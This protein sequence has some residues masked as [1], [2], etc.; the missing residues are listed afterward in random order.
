MKKHVFAICAYKE[1]PYLE[2]CI[3]SLRA[4]SVPATI[5][6]C[7]STPNEFIAG[8]TEKYQL[9]CYIRDGKSDIQAD[10][11]FAYDTADAEYVTIA[12]Q[13]DIYHRDYLKELLKQI[14]RHPDT[15]M[16]MTDYRI[17]NQ[18][19][20]ARWEPS[21][22]IKQILKL[23]LRISFLADK[24]LVK[25][26]IQAFGN[27]ICCPSV[28]YHKRMLGNDIF[29][30]KYKYALDWETFYKIAGQ[31]GRFTYLS[32]E[33]FYYRIHDKATSKAC[34]VNQKKTEEELEMFRK[35]WPEWIVQILMHFYKISYRSYEKV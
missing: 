29:H 6:M 20:Q 16:A 31:K 22:L 9:P 18:E 30:S 23:P 28:C 19:Q 5:I 17:I 15:L 26:G 32:K 24:K 4:Q 8:L 3:Q 34:L 21:L 2:S 12:H 10:W 35:F 14:Q 33:L 11:N 13:D 25:R 1:S 7:T 27:A